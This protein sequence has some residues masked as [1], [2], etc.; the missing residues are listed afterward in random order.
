MVQNGKLKNDPPGNAGGI[1]VKLK[2]YRKLNQIKSYLK[3][4][5]VAEVLPFRC[6]DEGVD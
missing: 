1:Q 6:G 5:D 3:S 2:T 4:G